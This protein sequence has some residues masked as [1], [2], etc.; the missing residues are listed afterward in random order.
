MSRIKPVHQLKGS[1]L[2]AFSPDSK[3]LAIAKLHGNPKAQLLALPAETELCAWSRLAT[4]LRA[5]A[6]S[7]DGMLVAFARMGRDIYCCDT[8]GTV[9]QHIVVEDG[10]ELSGLQFAPKTGLLVYA[11][12]SSSIHLFDSHSG[13][14]ERELKVEDD[15]GMVTGMC[16]SRQGALLAALWETG[17]SNNLTIWNWPSA[18]R[19]R[20]ITKLPRDVFDICFDAE[21]ESLVIAYEGGVARYSI[22]SGKQTAQLVEGDEAWFQAAAS[23]DGRFVALA[24]DER[25]TI[26]SCQQ[27][28]EAGSSELKS[29]PL[30]MEFSPNSEQL[31]I[32]FNRKIAI[33]GL[34]SLLD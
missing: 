30:Q 11:T 15:E 32:A 33:Y 16:F 24:S 21:G 5:I 13:A 31:A 6:F 23:P 7:E 2:F 1:D 17:N 3:S 12:E 22:T 34:E 8:K 10:N 18:R 26:W 29:E 27:E 25:L 14:Q 4:N 19:Q 9:L 20:T 28:R